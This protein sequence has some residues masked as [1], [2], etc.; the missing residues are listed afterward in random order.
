MPRIPLSQGPQLGTAPLQGVYQRAPDVSAPLR[1]LARAGA[2]WSDVLGREAERDAHAQANDAEARLTQGWMAWDAE[3]RK[4]YQGANAPQYLEEAQKWWQESAKTLGGELNPRAREIAGQAL[5]RRQ[6]AALGGVSSHVE[7]EKERHA[8][9]SALSSISTTIQFGVGSGDVAGASQ[10]VRELTAGIAARK[11]WSTEQLLAEQGKHLSSLHLAQINKLAM[12][13]AEAARSYYDLNKAEVG[14]QHQARVEEVLKGEA[15]NQAAQRDAASWATLPLEQQ[16][17][18]ASEVSDPQRR[19]KTLTAIRQQHALVKEA[20]QQREQQAGDAAWQLVGQGKRVPEG[21]LVGMDGR[22]RVQL[23][24]YLRQRAE[25][26]AA[27]GIKPVKTDDA[28]H[29]KLWALMTDDPEAFKKERLEAYGMKLSGSDFQELVNKQQAMR[30]PTKDPKDTV[31]WQNKI[32][33][34]T[35]MLGFS[36]ERNAEQRGQFNLSAQ[37]LFEEHE[38]RTG[39][40]PSPQEEDQIL[41]R[42]MLPGE[43]GLFSSGEAKTYAEAQAT[44]KAFVPKISGGDRSLIIKALQAE[45]IERPTEEQVTARYKLAKGLR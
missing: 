34:R 41:D 33:S 16:L 15:D 32:R 29:R 44:G 14:F 23:Q 12:T 2:A 6:S 43:T 42:L 25:H 21:L 27:N 31:T 3:A 45:G 20:Q 26:A 7:A 17:K 40:R 35:D 30:S 9:E 24:D 18:K 19:D 11:G 8:D 37:R 4:K 36:G 39:K 10:R 13:N 28:T 22:S 38:R 5:M 1:E